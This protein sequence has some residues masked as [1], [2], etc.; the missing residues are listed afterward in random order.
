MT[1]RK[2]LAGRTILITGANTGIGR[3]TA[4]ALGRRGARLYLAGRSEQ[5][6][7]AV[8]DELAA[9]GHRDASFLPLELGNLASVRACAERFLATG[10]P[11]HVLIDNAGLAGQTGVTE[12]GFEKTFGVNHLGHFLFTELLLDR[13]KESAPSRIVIVA[14]RAHY[15][16]KSGIDWDAL[17]KPTA[18]T[19][20]FPEYGVSKLCNVLHAKNLAR[21]LEGTG[22]TVYALHPGV[23]ATDVWREVPW[24]FRGLIKLFMKSEEEGAA[25]TIHCATSP[26]AAK[27]SGLYY[28]ECRPKEPS[29]FAKDRALE[30]ELYRRSVEWSGLAG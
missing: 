19:T 8:I 13:L 7:Q 10:E 25:T 9:L 30:D 3:T 15:R 4:L 12:D 2:D 26:D 28:E 14:S 6:M 21:R 5:K 18:T 23:V 16:V 11:L 22:V 29:R 20:G 1:D 27:E 17:R 24:P